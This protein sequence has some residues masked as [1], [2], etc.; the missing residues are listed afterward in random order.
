MTRALI[1]H[2]TD[3]A[4]V[5]DGAFRHALKL[6]LAQRARLRLVHVHDRERE[7]PA[8]IEAFPHVRET[9]V[10]WG[11]LAPGAPA[12][13]IE[14]QLGLSVS[15]AEAAASRP[16]AALEHLLADAAP[17]L[18]V[19]GTRG[20]DGLE[21]L[22][23]GSFAETLA[24]HAGAPALFVPEGARGFVAAEDGAFSLR[25]VLVP[26]AAAPAPARALAAACR[27]L[28]SIA[29]GARLHVLH[30]G[31][32]RDMPAYF[33][34]GPRQHTAIARQGPV[35]D[36]IVGVAEEIDADLIVM[37]TEGHQSLLDSLRGSTT[38]RVLRR[39]RRPLL[40]VPAA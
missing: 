24:R 34:P 4:A 12:A 2:A 18:I 23:Q 27:L 17:Q 9:L 30:V 14:A 10:K 26:I 28:D 15:K 13:A 8:P 37:A 5:S 1:I 21:L 22:R 20:A 32:A 31:E 16:E 38:E 6:G 7:A 36:T 40:A 3:L 33:I 29:S 25:N 19:L 35:V 39:A 11:M